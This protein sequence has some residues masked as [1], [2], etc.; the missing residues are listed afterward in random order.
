[1][2]RNRPRKTVT[3]PKNRVGINPVPP[4][5]GYPVAAEALLETCN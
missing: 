5:G 2:G 4:S 1:M 3:E